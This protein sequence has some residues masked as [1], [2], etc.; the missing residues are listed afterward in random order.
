[1]GHL[2]QDETVWLTQQQMADL[3]QIS[4]TNVV[5]HMKHI[6]GEGELDENSTCQ[7]FR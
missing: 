6:Y 2:L 3:F 1:M 5:E 7:K 4:R